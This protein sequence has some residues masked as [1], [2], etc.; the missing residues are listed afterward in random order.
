[1][2]YQIE[3]TQAKLVRVSQAKSS[4]SRWICVEAPQP[5]AKAVNARLSAEN[6]RQ[7]W[8]PEGF[9]RGYFVLSE[10]AE[11]IYKTTDYWAPE[12][13]RCI[14]WNDPTLAIAWPLEG[15]PTLSAKIS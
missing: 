1:M 9:A 3:K 10:Y 8:I 2:H 6:K 11:V 15:A 14:V 5:S 12:H 7:L 4:T 13:E